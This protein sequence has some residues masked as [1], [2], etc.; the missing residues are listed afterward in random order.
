MATAV[1][2]DGMMKLSGALLE[3]EESANPGT[4]MY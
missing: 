1:D 4:T 3:V 2:A